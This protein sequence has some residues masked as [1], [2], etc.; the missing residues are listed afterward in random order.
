MDSIKP[1]VVDLDGTLLR[2][3]TLHEAIAANLAHPRSLLR[4]VVAMFR[5]GKVALKRAFAE[6]ERADVQTAPLN[7]AVR[8]LIVARA[9]DGGRVFLATGA[10][11]A[12]ADAFLPRVPEIESAYTST[13]DLNFTSHEKARALVSEFGERGFDYVGNSPADRAVWRSADQAYL[14]TTRRAGVPRW[15]R[16]LVFAAVLRDPGPRPWRAWLRAV[17]I[18]QS[19]KNLLLFLP[20]VAAHQLTDLRAL[21]LA[22]GG[23]IAFTLMAASVYLLNDAVDLRADRAHARKRARPLAAGWISPVHA[24]VVAGILAILAIVLGTALSAAFL[25]VLLTYAALTLAYS[26]V[27]K[28]I[29]LIDVVVLALLYMVRIVAG[30]VVT[31]IALSFWFT[32]V[33]LFLFLSLALVKRYAEAHERREGGGTIPGRGYSGDDIHAILALGSGSGVA[34]TLLTAIYIQSE[35]VREIYAAPVVL[36]LVIPVMFFWVANLWLKAGRG[37]MHDDPVIFALRDRASLGAA[38]VMAVVFVIASLPL[39]AT[40]LPYA[41]V[42]A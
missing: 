34:A 13:G 22:V 9:E 30:A 35:A 17:R 36:W 24:L 39:T 31:G 23:F 14:A 7:S 4:A 38:L 27:L 20:L 29:A 28:R 26:F 1:L 19:L 18:H 33:A 3:D 16:D 2:S 42:I 41:R 40:I 21:A 12:V 5:G 11:A 37:L 8:D 10:D 15:A 6:T 25:G 32:G